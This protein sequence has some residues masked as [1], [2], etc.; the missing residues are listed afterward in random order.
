MSDNMD[1]LNKAYFLN[2]YLSTKNVSFDSFVSS[3]LVEKQ[4][5]NIIALNKQ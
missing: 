4:I 3:E 2:S 5:A 1:D